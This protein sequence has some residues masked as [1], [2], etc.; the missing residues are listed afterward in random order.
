MA[1][2]IDYGEGRV[3]EVSREEYIAL[4]GD[5]SASVAPVSQRFDFGEG[6]QNT[7]A[8][9]GNQNVSV[10]INGNSASGTVTY[11]QGGGSTSTQQ[12]ATGVTVSSPFVL[13][14]GNTPDTRPAGVV[15]KAEEDYYTEVFGYNITAVFLG[16][17]G[18]LPTPA[19]VEAVQGKTI[20]EIRATLNENLLN[21][22]KNNPDKKPTP[23]LYNTA[24]YAF[25]VKN[26][27]P[28]EFKRQEGLAI[29]T[30][31]NGGFPAD[32][33]I[34][35]S[36]D[37]RTGAIYI[38]RPS[39]FTEFYFPD[40]S[41]RILNQEQVADFDQ[42]LKSNPYNGPTTGKYG[43][44][45]S[46]IATLIYERNVVGYGPGYLETVSKYRPTADRPTNVTTQ[47]ATTGSGYTDQSRVGIIASP[48]APVGTLEWQIQNQVSRLKTD[49]ELRAWL[50]TTTFTAAQINAA[51]PEYSTADLQRVITEAKADGRADPL[52]PKFALGFADTSTT[53]QF[54]KYALPKPV[55]VDA[56]GNPIYA[57]QD[58]ALKA[59]QAIVAA[60][61]KLAWERAVREIYDRYNVGDRSFIISSPGADGY[62][63]IQIRLPDGSDISVPTGSYFAGI[64]KIITG[65]QFFFAQQRPLAEVETGYFNRVVKITPP[66]ETSVAVQLP[67]GQNIVVNKDSELARAIQYLGTQPHSIF[68]R[69][70]AEL[71]AEQ[72]ITDPYSDPATVK[73]AIDYIE[74]VKDRREYL[75]KNGLTPEPLYWDD[76]NWPKYVGTTKGA[77]EEATRALN[78]PTFRAQLI[79]SQGW[80]KDQYDSW[81]LSVLN[82]EEWAR[83]VAEE[84]RKRGV[85]AGPSSSGP[86]TSNY[87]LSPNG[88]TVTEYNPNITNNNGFANVNIF[89]TASNSAVSGL[90]VFGS[91]ATGSNFNQQAV[92]AALALSSG[93]FGTNGS[94]TGTPDGKTP[95]LVYKLPD[96]GF[97]LVFPDGTRRTAANQQV[98]DV[99]LSSYT[100]PS[101][102]NY[103]ISN[104]ALANFANSQ[105]T[106]V[107]SAIA[108]AAAGFGAG[109]FAAVPTDPTAAL[110]AQLEA[111]FSAQAPLQA[112]APVT[113]VGTGTTPA[114]PPALPVNTGNT[115]VVAEDPALREFDQL[116]QRLAAERL[117]QRQ[118][119][120]GDATQQTAATDLART[121][122]TLQARY[123]EPS[124]SDW[125]VRLQLAPGAEYLYRAS[126]PGILAPLYDTD[127]VIFP[128]VP[129]IETS[130]NA[131][132]DPYDLVHSNYRGYFYRGSKVN[133]IQ[134]RATFT[135]QDTQEANYLLAVIHF[136]RSVTKMFYG[137]KDEFRGTP[138]PLCYLT[139]F[140]SFQFNQHPVLVQSFSY[141]LPND[142][143]YI[144][145]RQ[146]NNYGT[147]L[148]TQRPRTG[149]TSLNP[150]TAGLQRLLGT[151]TKP[152]VG[153]VTTPPAP[154]ANTANTNNLEKATYVPTKLDLSLT[155][156][157]YN[158][159]GQ[160]SQT[161]N[162]KEFATGALI[163]GGFW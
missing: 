162:M 92:L 60:D 143:D 112:P 100:G 76:P 89:G 124:T 83:I 158:T 12:A 81:I 26:L 115:T 47:A 29:I 52:N 127:G 105:D 138:P 2:T 31:L 48:T 14:P 13:G 97:E 63:A 15:S 133:E 145:A 20:Y 163:K 46:D 153:A 130:Y 126:Q 55:K 6:Y 53:Q 114:E 117:A 70:F 43:V 5:T 142:V 128:Y 66:L 161:F 152:P 118:T 54:G 149:A 139:G 111:G 24:G 136:F 67:T 4:T 85:V 90:P 104:S 17:Y 49:I 50:A 16:A 38:T 34:A 106:T 82:P 27:S 23:T 78:D 86:G 107:N 132:Y 35:S 99:L 93:Q 71:W 91:G 39:G 36:Q 65:D 116:A 77:F 45:D 69:P 64:P 10:P 21:Y 9:G 30:A 154:S 68:H 44:S 129:Q 18:R 33:Y 84:E 144:R 72:G 131:V 80:D 79:A 11:N 110:L 108:A 19:E 57:A 121:Q 159:R 103:G 96:G 62:P 8:P 59:A 1:Y 87:Q 147:N 40:G 98:A 56:E 151:L 7:P 135:A 150:A 123:K 28:E 101:S 74:R 109:F 122:A 120:D 113:P 88:A 42:Y 160:V 146:P 148:Y 119:N 94:L 73:Y 37:A 95:V 51:F 125:R 155:L 32:G 3:V 22:Y 58:P 140:G 25:D 157:P 134:L 75:Q 137:A 102:G 156:L 141:Q 41:R 61:T